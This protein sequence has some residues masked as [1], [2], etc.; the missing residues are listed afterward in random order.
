MFCFQAVNPTIRDTTPG[1][2][3]KRSVEIGRC[4][5]RNHSAQPPSWRPNPTRFFQPRALCHG[6]TATPAVVGEGKKFWV[7]GWHP[8]HESDVPASRPQRQCPHPAAGDPPGDCVRPRDRRR[9]LPR[10]L[11]RPVA[12]GGPRGG[13]GWDGMGVDCGGEGEGIPLDLD[14]G[15]LPSQENWTPICG[16]RD[17]SASAGEGCSPDWWRVKQKV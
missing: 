2:A 12:G 7:V 15:Q 11:A 4:T 17:K 13:M 16:W 9:P 10:P 5:V 3:R 8:R 6:R 14:E 1:L